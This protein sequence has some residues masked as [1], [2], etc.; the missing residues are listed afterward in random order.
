[1]K[2]NT[3][4]IIVVLG[5][6]AIV[7]VL[8]LFLLLLKSSSYTPQNPEILI[9]EPARTLASACREELNSKKQIPFIADLPGL[10]ASLTQAENGNNQ[11]QAFQI[12]N[13]IKGTV[14]KISLSD[15]LVTGQ[16]YAAS[17]TLN[18][19]EGNRTYF[20]TRSDLKVM[21]I[22]RDNAPDLFLGFLDLKVGDKVTLLTTT[23]FAKK[24]GKN[25]TFIQ[26]T[27]ASE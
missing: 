12:T 9:A 22:A 4:L 26:I 11:I 23:D 24:S 20:Y 5:S 8:V 18:T 7:G 6:L 25:I 2:I 14:E 1:M 3:N 10:C 19:P 21:L 17:L 13:E 16:L 27:I 15:F